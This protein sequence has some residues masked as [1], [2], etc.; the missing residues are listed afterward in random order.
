MH[1][2][3][4]VLVHYNFFCPVPVM[5]NISGEGLNLKVPSLFGPLEYSATFGNANH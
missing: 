2:I 3:N 5:R 1:I 4:L